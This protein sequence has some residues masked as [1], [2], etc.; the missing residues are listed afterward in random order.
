M[1][2]ASLKAWPASL[3]YRLWL[4]ATF[5]LADHTRNALI[6]SVF[7]FKVGQ[8]TLLLSSIANVHQLPVMLQLTELSE[9][10]SV[11]TCACSLAL[12]DHGHFGL[13]GQGCCFP[14]HA[15]SPGRATHTQLHHAALNDQLPAI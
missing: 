7:A 9:I 8:C 10:G 6:L 13:M 1:H 4:K 5:A 2:H 14:A 15:E 3:L 12:L 11:V